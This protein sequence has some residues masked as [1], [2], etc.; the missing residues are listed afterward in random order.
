MYR[1]FQKV[2]MESES[3]KS[4]NRSGRYQEQRTD[5]EVYGGAF[6]IVTGMANNA[7]YSAYTPGVKD[8]NILTIEAPDAVDAIGVYVVDVVKISDATG[9]NNVYR[10]GA[11]TIGLKANAGENVAMRKLALQD[12]FI[13]GRE[14]FVSAPTVGEYAKLTV[15]SV[16]LTPAAV[17]PVAG[18]CVAI[19]QRETISQ[20]TD[21]NVDAYLCRIVQL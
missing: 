13:L 3:V 12:E 9:M 11:K 7:V 4:Q 21:G 2:L 5:A 15:G 16:D 8:F 14:N 19:E 6:V 18:L 20:G 1:F 17:I 10:I